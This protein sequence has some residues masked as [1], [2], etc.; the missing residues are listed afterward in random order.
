QK[1]Q[2]NATLQLQ[3]LREINNTHPTP[4]K[5]RLDPIPRQKI[6]R[7]KISRVTHGRPRVEQRSQRWET[8][9]F[10]CR[11]RQRPASMALLS[12]L[13][14]RWWAG[15]VNHPAPCVWGQEAQMTS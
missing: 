10:A 7:R 3:M 1:L 15:R 5:D 14:P 12:D 13:R 11:Q 4:T 2:R 6:A 9:A 8:H